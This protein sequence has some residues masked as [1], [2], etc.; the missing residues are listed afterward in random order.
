MLPTLASGTAERPSPQMILT[1]LAA[2]RQRRDFTLF[3]QRAWPIV[4]PKRCVWNW[5]MDAICEHLLLVTQGEIRNLMI[6]IP[7]RMT[8]SL[9][10]SVLWPVWH[11]IQRPQTQF[12][13]A[14]YE[15]SLSLE[16][17]QASRRLIE[18]AWFKQFY[19]GEW[20]LLPDENKK[21][22]Y[23]NSE[24]GYRIS[25]SVNGKTTGFGADI[26]GLDDPHNIKQAE[27]D[28]QRQSAIEWHDNSWRSRMNDPNRAQKVYIAQ[29]THDVDVFGHVLQME[30][31]RWTV[32]CLPMEFDPKRICI[33]YP[34]K[35]TGVAPDAKAIF[36][37]PRKVDG[38]LLNPKRFNAE[39]AQTEKDAMSVRAWNAQ[40]QQQPEGQG[41]LI[42]KRHWWK[43][44]VYP[45]WHIEA[46]KERP[47]PEFIEI[48]QVYD[49][50][51]E[52]EEENDFSARTT[53]GIFAHRETRKDPMTGRTVEGKQRVCALLLDWWEERVGFPELRS[54][55]IR[56]YNEFA[57]EWVLIEKKAS[58]HS[59]V[60]ELRKKKL[61]V[62]A[63]KLTDG[64]DLVARVHMASLMLE[65]SAIYYIPRKWSVR[66][67]EQVAKFPNG[68]HDDTES[69]LAIAW[70][71]MR[72]YHDLTLP[73]DDEEKEISPFK[74]RKRKYG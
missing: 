15:S 58:G 32:V 30:P 49:T 66:L 37:D 10:C 36:R 52:E 29:R 47:L 12:M 17:A 45:D 18:S 59:L 67:I 31:N 68:E 23:R 38:E 39:T 22:L 16:F 34:N 6:Q 8:K 42:L 5:H 7:P 28:T 20:Y 4:E 44:W 3:A 46:G 72:K 27:S 63:V 40:Y 71:F 56:A 48:I 2:E 11:W 24:G 70:Q 74:W 1:A 62:K 55:A 25:T 19:G 64:G 60:Q 9:L 41:G 35:G 51:F 65:K 57:P 61:P 69:T 73:D 26:L 54:E 50:A 53:W 33:T 13:W 21:E 14:S 43:Q